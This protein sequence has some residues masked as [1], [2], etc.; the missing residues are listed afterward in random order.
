MEEREK[1]ERFLVEAI[2][3]AS[4]YLPLRVEDFQRVFES[5]SSAR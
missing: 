4:E 1:V 3:K 5:Y 2:R